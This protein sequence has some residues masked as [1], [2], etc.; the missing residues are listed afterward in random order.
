MFLFLQSCSSAP[1]DASCLKCSPKLSSRSLVSAPRTS[2]TV[3]TFML[4]FIAAAGC[5]CCPLISTCPIS[6]DR[7]FTVLTLLT[8]AR[9][10]RSA[11]CSLPLCFPSGF[12]QMKILFGL[13][14]QFRFSTTPLAICPFR[15]TTPILSAFR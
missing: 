12:S 13:R 10:S 1:P 6:P 4:G 11:F 2:P 14:C 5:A 15:L 9:T 3:L 8:H 7:S